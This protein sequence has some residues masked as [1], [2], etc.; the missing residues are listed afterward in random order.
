M[1]TS[2]G[3]ICSAPIR[4]D[5]GLRRCT[6]SGSARTE[7]PALQNRRL[8]AADYL[9][10]VLAELVVWLEDLKIRDHL[11]RSRKIAHVADASDDLPADA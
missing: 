3:R 2:V 5:D 11:L 4:S 9:S 10:A 8:E 6:S 7:N 1:P